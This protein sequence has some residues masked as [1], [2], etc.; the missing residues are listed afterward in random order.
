MNTDVC[1][2]FLCYKYKNVIDGWSCLVHNKLS[3]LPISFFCTLNTHYRIVSYSICWLRYDVHMLMRH[4][5]ERYSGSAVVYIVIFRWSWLF[6]HWFVKRS[7]FVAN[8]Q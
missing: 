1:I 6:V 7:C 3:W 2:R 5:D 8:V 4:W